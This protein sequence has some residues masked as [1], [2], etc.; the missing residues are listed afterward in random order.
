MLLV[1]QLLLLLNATTITNATTNANATTI[2]NAASP[3][4]TMLCL[5]LP[6]CRSSLTDSHVSLSLFALSPSLCLC[7]SLSVPLSVSV[8]LSPP[9]H[10]G[11]Y[12]YFSALFCRQPP[13]CKLH[14]PRRRR[15]VRPRYVSISVCPFKTRAYL[16]VPQ[17]D[18]SLDVCVPVRVVSLCLP[19]QD[20]AP[21]V[22]NHQRHRCR[23]V[24]VSL[25]KHVPIG[26]LPTKGIPLYVC[27][28][29]RFVLTCVCP[30]KACF[31]MCVSC[32]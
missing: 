27:V 12:I 9:S 17:Q 10:S 13:L 1:Q 31:Y 2:T 19:F 30:C 18:V 3:T 28:L 6:P 16:Y 24:C 22:W 29:L 4:T 5:P 8:Y 21:C 32:F 23:Y 26:I 11:R 25:L 7:L 15:S 20:I 14:L